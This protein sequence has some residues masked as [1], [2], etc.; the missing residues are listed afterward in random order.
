MRV[1]PSAMNVS[2]GG[3]AHQRQ[4]LGKGKT[5]RQ[6]SNLEDQPD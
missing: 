5:D 2:E 6:F 4:N 3:S 1:G